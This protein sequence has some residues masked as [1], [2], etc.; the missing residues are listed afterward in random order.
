MTFE[1][2]VVEIISQKLGVSLEKIRNQD[3]FDIDLGA[4]SL[5]RMELIMEFEDRFGID[6]DDREVER[7]T[8]VQ[9]AINYLKNHVEG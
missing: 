5:D 4:D 3:R 8:T 6:I 1:E 2:R 7:I 9:E